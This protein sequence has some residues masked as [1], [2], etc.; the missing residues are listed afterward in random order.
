MADMQ[1]DSARTV[2]EQTYQRLR[3]MIVSKELKPGIVLEERPLA[4][5]MRVSRT[6][7]RMALSRLLGE[8]M[9]GRLSNGLL[10]VCEVD[11]KEYFELLHIRRALE[12]EAAALAA[13]QL[14]PEAAADLRARITAIMTAGGAD[15]ESHWRIDDELHDLIAAASGSRWLARLIGDVRRRARM[16]NIERLPKRLAET[17]EEHL[18]L[19]DALESGD[20]DLARQRMIEHLD[21]VREGF[22][23][24]LKI[25]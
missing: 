17:C 7:M 19:L 21:K 9:I 1:T 23:A 12:S 8:G 2:S 25:R 20:A 10:I 14:P 24:L 18:N 16:C 13:G 4:E 3:S 22:V 5:R 11:M 6:P 15:T